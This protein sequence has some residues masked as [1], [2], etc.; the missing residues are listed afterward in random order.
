MF[1]CSPMH[2]LSHWIHLGAGSLLIQLLVSVIRQICSN[3]R[4]DSMGTKRLYVPPRLLHL[5]LCKMLF[6]RLQLYDLSS[7]RS[8]RVH[9]MPVR[10]VYDLPKHDQHKWDM[11]SKHQH[12]NAGKL[13][14]EQC[15]NWRF[16]H[17]NQD[18][19]KYLRKQLSVR[20]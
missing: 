3:S 8:G 11:Y 16:L 6:V 12:S 9:R 19:P 17:S 20:L 13:Y 5:L 10:L 4:F 2:N 14:R 15:T 18:L 7:S 1:Q